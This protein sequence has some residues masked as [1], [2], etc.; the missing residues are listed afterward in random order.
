MG[1]CTI[2]QRGLFLFRVKK[3]VKNISK[4]ANFLE[5]ILET[6]DFMS[7]VVKT[8]EYYILIV[9]LPSFIFI[10]TEP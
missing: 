10:C 4:L 2:N 5:H 9:L 1:I 8:L 3:C 6:F 7:R